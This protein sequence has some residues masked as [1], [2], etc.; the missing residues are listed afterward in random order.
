[1][2]EVA[3]PVSTPDLDVGASAVPKASQTLSLPTKLI[4]GF[5]SVAFGVKDNGFQTILLLFYN[6]VVGLPA[7]LVGLAVM[8]ALMSDAIMDPVIG[9]IS[10]NLR[11]PWGRRH[12]L[13][14][15]SAIPVGLSY[16][17]L[18]SPPMHASQGAQ[19]AYLVL[20]SILVRTFISLYEAPSAALAPELST[21]YAE[22]TSIL[23]F[24]T[25]F[26]WFGGLAI[27]FLAFTVFLRPDATHKV[28]QL[29]P[30]GYA[31][32]GLA[33][34]IVMIASILISAAGTHSRIKT[35]TKPPARRLSLGLIFKEIR[36]SLTH[37]SFLVLMASLLFSSAGSGAAFSMALYLYTFFWRLTAVQISV[38]A[39][40]NLMSA[41]FALLIVRGVAR[42]DKRVASITAAVSGILI[43]CI[44]MTL[45]LLGLFPANSSPLL[46]PLLLSFSLVGLGALIAAS[47]TGA[48]MMAD[49]V[50]D[51]ELRTGRRSEG[52]FF[53]ASL[54][55]QK[56]VSGL[57]IF[58]TGAI[59]SA[60]HF[61]SAARVG[62]V[63]PT[64]IQN[65]ALVYMPVV[66]LLFLASSL[67]LLGY[68]ITR[69]VHAENLRRLAESGKSVPNLTKA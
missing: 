38:F 49:V 27:Y 67:C 17:L 22:R 41:A 56:A 4:Y 46:F 16:L 42:F 32:Y 28:G 53:A 59:L 24:R 7:N 11:T 52:L 33:A 63:D 65:L 54:F 62:A 25:F 51:S 48:S 37:R 47:I 61:P 6:Q 43:S 66:M 18:W 1:M 10:D 44:P 8:I 29:N 21:N 20:V 2:A 60:V 40:V 26:Q 57:G 34:C 5:G 3:L 68:R 13:M 15:A 31:H 30:V 23:G 50:E 69:A 35:L 45:R 58:I 39:V 55:V 19:L 36:E 12:P 9:Q 64:T 14:Y